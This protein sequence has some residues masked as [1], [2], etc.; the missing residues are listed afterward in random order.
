M[1]YPDAAADRGAWVADRGTPPVEPVREGDAT[2][3]AFEAPFARDAKLPRTTLDRDVRLDLSVAGQFTLRIAVEEPRAVGQVSLYFRSGQGWYAAG[4]SLEKAG[5]HTLQFSKAAFRTEGTPAGWDKIDGIRISLWRG[6][7]VDAHVRLGRLAAQWHDV[8]L[9]VPAAERQQGEGRAAA[10]AAEQVAGLLDEL[11]LGADAID[12]AAVARGALGSR[13]VAVLA[14]NP[15]IDQSAVA[16]LAEFVEKGG[17]LFACYQLPQPLAKAIGLGPMRYVRPD[18]PGTFSEIRFDAAGVPGLPASVRQASWN[19]TA[20]EPAGYNARVV[21]SWFDN[22]GQPTGHAA[23]VVSGRGAFFSHVLLMDDRPGKKQMLAAILGRLHPPLWATMARTALDRSTRVGHL[24]DLAALAAR[25]AAGANAE[26][27]A[28]LALGTYTLQASREAI[29]RGEYRQAMEQASQTRGYLAAAYVRAQPSPAVEGRAFW[30][31]SGTGAY[32]GDWDRTAQQLA[33]AGFNMVVPNMLWG[34]LAHSPS[35]VLPQSDTFRKHG[36]QIAQCV[37][38]C[39]RHGVEVHVWKVNFNLSTAPKEFVER[40]QRAGRTQVS[41]E[42]EPIDWLC[43]SHPE[44]RKLEIDSMLEVARKYDV[45]GLHFDY[46]RY[47]HGSAC[48]CGGCR[49][50]F[51]AETGVKVA[52]WPAGVR[53]D[54]RERDR[55]L[56]WRCDQITRLVAAVH[57][58]AKQ[59]NPR[60]KISA[61]VFGAYPD[62]R[63]S[64]GQDWVAWVEAGYLDFVCPMD[65]NRSDEAFRGLVENQLRLVRGR[66]PL[67]PGIG[68]WLL[69]SPDRVVGQIHHARSLGAQGFT[70]FNLDEGAARDVLPAVAAGAGS[71]RATP[72]HAGR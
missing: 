37:A 33:A 21:G 15:Q 23:L 40:M 49:E 71:Q 25:V 59:I 56:Q 27:M 60:I 68:A 24:D 16:A 53:S 54:G 72:Q 17:K 19:I 58:E 7:A 35:D 34:G 13:R 22:E 69:E 67:Y 66:V 52:N 45:D 6:Q 65:Y 48:Y 2:A 55:Y 11:G 64:V 28:A 41:A 38:A 30:N 57:D 61:A 51:Q 14:Y 1:T 3:V 46:I 62:C 12:D 70:V 42:A 63:V 31:H 39:K 43:P 44:N 50:R 10:E 36:D 9:V 20:P 4:A 32:P 47:P 18:R 5:W 29:V 26:A 8:A